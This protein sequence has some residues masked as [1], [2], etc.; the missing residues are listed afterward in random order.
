MLELRLIHKHL[1][2][3]NKQ[4]TR[5]SKYPYVKLTLD[6]RFP[7]A[8][9]CAGRERRRGDVSRPNLVHQTSQAADR[10]NRNCR[11]YSSLHHSFEQRYR[12]AHVCP[13]ADRRGCVSLLGGNAGSRLS[14]HGRRSH[15]ATAATIPTAFWLPLKYGS[16]SSPQP[17]A[18][19]RRPT[20]GIGPK[21]WPARSARGRRFD[22]LRRAGRV[23]FLDRRGVG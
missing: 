4:L 6:E 19:K 21:H 23:R 14:T 10:S 20:C 12:E 22:L 16:A 2:R 18:S 5:S 3:Y 17:S 13:C 15:R 8:L 1:P 9:C 11:T 7:S